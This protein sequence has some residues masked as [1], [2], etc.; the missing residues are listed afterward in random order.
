VLVMV[1]RN[2]PENNRDLRGAYNLMAAQ[3]RLNKHRL[4]LAA[5]ETALGDYTLP[6][7]RLSLRTIIERVAQ[8]YELSAGDLC[9]K[10]RTERV[11]EVRQIAM[12]LCRDL[13]EFSLPQI[14][15][16]LGGRSHTTVLHGCNKVQEEIASDKVL[17]AKIDRLRRYVSTGK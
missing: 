11:N 17:E 16:E 13:T 10:K 7:S 8:F 14:G 9:G 1:A 5:A 4:P 6:R 2:I 3:S 12:F 15:D